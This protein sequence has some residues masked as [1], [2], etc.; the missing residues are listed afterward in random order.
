MK[1]LGQETDRARPAR[2]LARITVANRTLRVN[3][4]PYRHARVIVLL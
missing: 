3:V 4:R 1:R 2:L